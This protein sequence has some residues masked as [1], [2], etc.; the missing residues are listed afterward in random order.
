MLVPETEKRSVAIAAIR[1]P[2]LSE[3]ERGDERFG[4]N[5]VAIVKQSF[6][7]RPHHERPSGVVTEL[8]QSQINP[9]LAATWS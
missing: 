3:G 4:F 6:D 7:Q 2:V 8:L 5:V 9:N 1:F